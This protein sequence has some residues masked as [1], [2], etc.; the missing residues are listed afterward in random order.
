MKKVFTTGQVAK[1]CK[2]AP[3]TVSKWFD[4]GRLRGYPHSTPGIAG[5]PAAPL[6]VPQRARRYLGDLEA[7]VYL[8]GAGRRGEVPLGQPARGT[9][10][11]TSAFHIETAASGFEADRELHRLHRH[12][13]GR[14]PDRVDESFEQPR[15]DHA[16]TILIA[17]T[18]DGPAKG[19]QRFQRRRKPF[20]GVCSPNGSITHSPRPGTRPEP[21]NAAPNEQMSITR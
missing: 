14:R 17:L 21:G 8:Q 16:S 19:L 13:S 15:S 6:P 10:T 3:R 7:E 1:I 12:R 5:I 11:K 4:S 9:S 20:D 18:S 2:V